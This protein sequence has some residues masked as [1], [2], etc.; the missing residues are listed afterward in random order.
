MAR[1]SQTV[2][3]SD[4]RGP[5]AGQAPGIPGLLR[6]FAGTRP[7]ATLLPLPDEGFAPLTIGRDSPVLGEPDARM[8]RLHARISFEDGHFFAVDLDSRNGTAV[9]GERIKPQ[10]PCA[11]RTLL[12]MG[13][14]LFLPVPDLR[15][16]QD[17]ALQ[18]HKD[19]IYGPLMQQVLRSVQSA[20]QL[21][22]TLHI[23]GESG[24]GKELIARAF[25]AQGS[26]GGGFVA[27]NCATIPESIAERLLFGAKRGAFSGAEADAPGYVQAAD[28]GTLFLD[29]L[30]E[31]GAPVQAKLL[32]VLESREVLP[33]GATRAR[34]VSLRICSATHRDLRAQVAAG[35][36][37]EDL[38]FRL[39]V[40]QVRVP[41]LRQRRE[42]IPWLLQLCLERHAPSLQLHVSLVEAVLLRPWR[43]NVRELLAETQAAAHAA[44]TGGHP[45]LEVQHLGPSAGL[46][47]AEAPAELPRPPAPAPEP[48]VRELDR[49]T[50]EAALHKTQGNVS[51]AARLLGLHRTQ[52][53][54][55][56][57]RN[58]MPGA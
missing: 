23:S 9:D 3:Q 25:H 43:G 55:F 26:G 58:G 22:T 1:P 5:A 50:V 8:S 41:P 20:A 6:I 14:S 4:V 44:L 18:V 24:T 45:R 42:E 31:L 28:S 19:A 33:V 39:A 34:A 56:L 38:Y 46:L 2:E 13:D 16:F 32:R 53:R 29:E 27:V 12:R 35:K 21:G 11:V 15:P 40:P 7:T 54:R 36:L 30:A 51:A 48:P 37:R 49:A 47:F 57:Q 52:L 17:H 10:V